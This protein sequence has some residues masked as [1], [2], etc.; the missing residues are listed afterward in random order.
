[1]AEHKWMI[2]LGAVFFLSFFWRLWN[3]TA[4]HSALKLSVTLVTSYLLTCV[5]NPPFGEFCSNF[6]RTKTSKSKFQPLQSLTSF[7]Y[8]FFG[9]WPSFFF[10]FFSC[11]VVSSP[12]GLVSAGND[13]QVSGCLWV[14]G[15]VGLLLL[16]LL[17]LLLWCQVFRCQGASFTQA[18]W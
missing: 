10:V 6:P 15:F 18:W 16:L 7:G 3:G 13:L 4:N 5:E 14:R 12:L 9:I 2:P 11:Q 17:L 1:M 8:I